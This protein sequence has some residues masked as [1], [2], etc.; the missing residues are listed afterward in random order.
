VAVLALLEP[1]K[2]DYPIES[3]DQIIRNFRVLKEDYP[4][5]SWDL[6]TEEGEG[7]VE[8]C[9][10]GGGILESNKKRE[11]GSV[12]GDYCGSGEHAHQINPRKTYKWGGF[13]G[14]GVLRKNKKSFI[15]MVVSADDDEKVDHVYMI[16]SS[17]LASND[18]LKGF[19]SCRMPEKRLEGTKTRIK[20]LSRFIDR[21]KQHAIANRF[22]HA[23]NV[24]CLMWKCR[25]QDDPKSFAKRIQL[26]GH[27]DQVG[28]GEGIKDEML[29][30]DSM[31]WEGTFTDET[32]VKK[33]ISLAD[34]K[35]DVHSWF[36][37]TG[38]V[39]VVH[40]Y[41]ALDSGYTRMMGNL[42]KGLKALECH[43]QFEPV[44]KSNCK[45]IVLA[46][47]YGNGG[48]WLNRMMNLVLQ[49][50]LIGIDRNVFKMLPPPSEIQ[51][52]DLAEFRTT[53]P[54]MAKQQFELYFDC[55]DTLTKCYKEAESKDYE[56]I[57]DLF[58]QYLL[59]NSNAPR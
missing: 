24:S 3:L 46:P 39:R 17:T 56:S 29:R 44:F 1:C 19:L 53:L 7:E 51:A 23:R 18:I 34:K 40:V 9:G 14:A 4:I 26:Y 10:Y 38:N 20:V 13:S 16:H 41:N 55:E 36:A 6:S 32:F 30:L 27:V 5:V 50:Q 31:Q 43:H 15:G 57:R 2:E 59:Q 12:V 35:K 28:I 45:L 25:S 42:V 52:R 37:E 11:L 21:S 58:E 54:E 47:H 8:F 48:L 49:L 33:I 22:V